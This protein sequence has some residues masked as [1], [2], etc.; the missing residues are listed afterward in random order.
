VS[1]G[2]RADPGLVR[3]VRTSNQVRSN[4]LST[5]L[6][7]K[8]GHEVQRSVKDTVRKDRIKKP[9]KP[10]FPNSNSGI[11]LDVIIVL[12]LFVYYRQDRA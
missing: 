5:F 9:P 4:N 8:N 10:E 12:V 3:I 2:A 11:V 6:Q 1:I 7:R